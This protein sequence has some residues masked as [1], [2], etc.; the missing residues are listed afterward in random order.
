MKKM[1]EMPLNKLTEKMIGAAYR[2]S[3]TLGVGFLEKVYR[4][5]YLLELK[6]VCWSS[7]NFLS[8]FFTMG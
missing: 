5:A 8:R 3:N 7:R 2:L 4:N 1:S 6:K